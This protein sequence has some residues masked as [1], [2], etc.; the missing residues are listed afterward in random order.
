MQRG[1]KRPTWVVA[2]ATISALVTAL[3]VACSQPGA[4]FSTTAGA[5]TTV[6]VASPAPSPSP[7]EEPVLVPDV[8]GKPQATAK[9]VLVRHGFTFKVRER[10]TTMDQ[11]PGWVFAEHPPASRSLPPGST[12]HVDVAVAT[13][14]WGYNFGCCDIIRSPPSSFCSVFRCV[15]RFG[16]GTGWVAECGD[17]LYTRQG[18]VKGACAK[19]R[20][21]WRSLLAPPPA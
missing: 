18:G 21:L 20:G 14:Q 9:K 3:A 8:T 12:V 7:T 4:G 15:T 19:H 17:G 1:R 11:P 6:P 10:V 5:G 13:N 2:T 16:G